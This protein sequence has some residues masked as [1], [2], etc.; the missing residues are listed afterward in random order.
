MSSEDQS[1]FWVMVTAADNNR[2]R[3]NVILY[4]LRWDLLAVTV[5][6]CIVNEFGA[7]IPL[8]SRKMTT[9]FS[10]VRTYTVFG[11]YVVRPLLLVYYEKMPCQLLNPD[12][13]IWNNLS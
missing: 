8:Q 2:H 12:S 3:G 10:E 9:F 7:Y 5:M 1:G 11:M 4:K 6:V 13:D